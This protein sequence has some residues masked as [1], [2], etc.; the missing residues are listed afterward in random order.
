MTVAG[1]KTNLSLLKKIFKKC[2]NKKIKLFCMYGQ[3][4]A[5]SRI[6]YLNPKYLSKKIGS[7]GK[8]IPGGKLFI[9]D[10]KN[11]AID[12]PNKKGQLVYKG[13]I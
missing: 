13:K 9:F 5:N 2:K 10:K 8:A 3:A 12:A 1:G 4:E 7:I 6:S 11:K